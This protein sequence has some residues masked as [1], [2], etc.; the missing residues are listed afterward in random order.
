MKVYENKITKLE[1][2]LNDLREPED[3]ILQRAI[4]ELEEFEQ[5][6]VES[7]ELFAK[8]FQQSEAARVLKESDIQAK[9][10]AGVSRAFLEYDEG[11]NP[12]WVGSMGNPHYKN[13]Y[14]PE[15]QRT[16]YMNKKEKLSI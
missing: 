16:A 15:T 14:N 2:Q 10:Q 7:I 6:Q 8:E 1:E 3:K 11:T 12:D 13:V 4:D 5:Q 9:E